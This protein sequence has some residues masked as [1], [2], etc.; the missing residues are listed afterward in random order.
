MEV[1]GD[2]LPVHPIFIGNNPV[3]EKW[4]LFKEPVDYPY[5]SRRFHENGSDWDELR[6]QSLFFCSARC[7]TPR[8]GGLSDVLMNSLIMRKAM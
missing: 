1:Q 6:I 8:R 3:R 2:V 5:G 4:E 7:S